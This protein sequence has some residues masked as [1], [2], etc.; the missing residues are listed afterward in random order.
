MYALLYIAALFIMPGVIVGSWAWL[1][2]ARAYRAG[3]AWT[4]RGYALWFVGLCLLLVAWVGLMM[5]LPLPF[6]GI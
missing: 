6:P 4:D 5:S 1:M 2:D 3:W